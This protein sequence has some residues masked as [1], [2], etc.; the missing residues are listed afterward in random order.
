MTFA[1]HSMAPVGSTAKD[2]LKLSSTR[3]TRKYVAKDVAVKNKKKEKLLRTSA[4]SRPRFPSDILQ[5]IRDEQLANLRR[6]TRCFWFL[7][8]NRKRH[9]SMEGCHVTSCQQVSL[10]SLVLGLTTYTF[11]TTGSG[12]I[13]AK[14]GNLTDYCYLIVSLFLSLLRVFSARFSFTLSLTSEN[15]LHFDTKSTC[16]LHVNTSIKHWVH[17]ELK[18]QL[19]KL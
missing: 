3:I 5:E 17:R 4:R 8:A 10:F 18:S 2:T 13:H 7:L 15:S 9:E 14:T 12:T 11:K 6:S 1:K 19:Q 16:K